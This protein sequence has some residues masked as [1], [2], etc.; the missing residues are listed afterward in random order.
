MSAVKNNHLTSLLN[1]W[2]PQKDELD[3]VL[4]TI[5][6][7]D[8]SSYRKPGAIMFI[9]SLGQYYGLLSGGCLEADIMRQ[10]RKCWDSGKSHIIQ[11]DMRDEDDIAWKLGIGCGGMVRILLQPVTAQNHYLELTALKTQLD[12]NQRCIY[13]L[14]AEQAEAKNQCIAQVPEDKSWTLNRLNQINNENWF[15]SE[16]LPVVRLAI[17]GGGIDAIPLANIAKQLGWHITLFDERL[18]YAKEAFFASVDDIVRDKLDDLHNH[19]ALAQVSAVVL[20][21][22]NVTMDAKSLLLSQCSG[23]KYVGMLGPRHRTERVFKDVNIVESQLT[24]PLHN[25]IG[26]DLGG[27]LP[28]SIALSML[29]EIHAVLYGASGRTLTRTRPAAKLAG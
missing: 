13:M 15:V 19:P 3:W 6:E 1:I 5:I 28:E 2:F 11:Y 23:A 25:P 26:F 29:S 10:A 17:F 8:G 20:M 24:K 7:T 18:G 16:Q 22:H 21:N 12:T 14:L 27:E 4:A 9:N